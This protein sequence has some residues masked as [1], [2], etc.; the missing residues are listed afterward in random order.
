M[1]IHAG[2]QC[3]DQEQKRFVDIKP[4]LTV[5]HIEVLFDNLFSQR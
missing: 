2:L 3:R 4:V 1:D 5:K